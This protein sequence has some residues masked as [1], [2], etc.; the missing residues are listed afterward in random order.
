MFVFY[1]RIWS[2]ALARVDLKG[3][4]YSGLIN[5]EDTNMKWMFWLQIIE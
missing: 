2:V 5:L 4:C 1:V 3:T